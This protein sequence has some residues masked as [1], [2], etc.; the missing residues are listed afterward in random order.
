MARPH[1]TSADAKPKLPQQETEHRSAKFDVEKKLSELRQE[2]DLICAEQPDNFLFF[3]KYGGTVSQEKFDLDP[4]TDLDLRLVC[5][6]LPEEKIQNEIRQR[7]Q[8]I[9]E[10]L[11]VELYFHSYQ[12]YIHGQVGETG[13]TTVLEKIRSTDTDESTVVRIEYPAMLSFY[14]FATMDFFTNKNPNTLDAWIQSVAE[15]HSQKSNNA[16]FSVY[17]NRE[18]LAPQSIIEKIRITE[19]DIIE[20]IHV[21]IEHFLHDFE[22]FHKL[23]EKDQQDS[24]LLQ[25]Y[26][27]RLSKYLIRIAFGV[28]IL[29]SGI[30]AL[31]DIQAHYRM[32][33]EMDISAANTHADV[34]GI[35]QPPW[36]NT[37]MK[38]I[39]KIATGIRTESELF[40]DQDDYEVNYL[41][42]ISQMENT[43]LFIVQQGGGLIRRDDFNDVHD[44]LTE[45]AVL[46]QLERVDSLYK[47]ETVPEGTRLLE[48][49]A[50]S[51]EIILVPTTQ[52]SGEPNAKYAI[53]VGGEKIVF[54]RSKIIVGELGVLLNSS[55]TASVVAEGKLEI[56]RIPK[57]ELERL[58]QTQYSLAG[59]H[60]GYTLLRNYLSG[61][62]HM[63]NREFSDAQ[64]AQLIYS[65]LSYFTDEFFQYL[66]DGLNQGRTFVGKEE[67]S[68]DTLLELYDINFLPECFE[69]FLDHDNKAN[70]VSTSYTTR[71]QLFD[72]GDPSDLLYFI[73]S[74]KESGGVEIEFSNGEKTVLSTGEIVGEDAL[75][76]NTSE[77]KYTATILP[78]TTVISTTAQGL[79]DA[80]ASTKAIFAKMKDENGTTTELKESSRKEVF[81]AIGVQCLQRLQSMYR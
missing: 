46:N 48:E 43:L 63:R 68:N 23:S 57:K 47:R 44:F 33:L 38:D 77:R 7:L 4:N 52:S 15:R 22:S 41:T 58:F 49:G 36:Y 62:Y 81:F 50:K 9:G 74:T 13:A 17:P 69:W 39:I 56:I 37:T 14:T 40:F 76:P 29:D 66:T 34:I 67:Q 42:L 75:L 30:I 28:A 16:D 19:R 59:T 27:S 12:R 5:F 55:R 65:L 8:K 73:H 71:T 31:S 51:E 20:W 64:D 1:E 79:R 2:C 80:T 53:E 35:I 3:T 60:E 21:Y 78:G 24:K 72:I 54:E 70:F 45:H 25:T 26:L 32:L 6:E 61:H 18:N 10:Q 11:D